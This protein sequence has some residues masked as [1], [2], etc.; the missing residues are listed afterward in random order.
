VKI[1]L[2]DCA[3]IGHAVF[4]GLGELDYHGR[5]TGVVF[6]FLK[7]DK[8]QQWEAAFGLNK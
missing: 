3:N 4:H 2:I 5:Q 1:M 8:L 7:P 6:G